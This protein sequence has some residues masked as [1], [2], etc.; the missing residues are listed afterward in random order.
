MKYITRKG[1]KANELDKYI[2]AGDILQV[3]Y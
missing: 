3:Y 2:T 1:K